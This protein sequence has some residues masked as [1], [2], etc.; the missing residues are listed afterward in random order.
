MCRTQGTSIQPKLMITV[1][2]RYTHTQQDNYTSQDTDHDHGS[3]PMKK[4]SRTK[5]TRKK[6][7]DTTK[8]TRKI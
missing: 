6:D 8:L 1:R 3:I 7:M 4:S 2:G 5:W